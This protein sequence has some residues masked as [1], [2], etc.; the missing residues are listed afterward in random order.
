MIAGTPGTIAVPCNDLARYHAFTTSLGSLIK[1]E[2]TSLALVQSISIP[3]NLNEAIAGMLSRPDDR[4]IF[5][6]GDDMAFEP[7]ALTRLLEHD[8]DVVVPMVPRRRPPFM[9]VL[10]KEQGGKLMPLPFGEVPTS[11]LIL[12]PSAGTG[13][14]LVKRE[15]FEKIPPPWFTYGSEDMATEDIGWCERLAAAGYSVH[16]DTE[17]RMGHCGVFIAWP[18]HVGGDR[19]SEWVIALQLGPRQQDTLLLEPGEEAIS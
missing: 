13:G 14:M 10:Y 5:F 15:C 18:G 12:V 2:G 19:Q 1:P 16:V 9:T 17:V 7:T 3:N 6:L 11:G 4:W 8:V